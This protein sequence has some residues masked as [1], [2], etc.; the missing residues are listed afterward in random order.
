MNRVHLFSLS[1]LLSCA[2]FPA[3]A[4]P[5]DAPSA[6]PAL[7]ITKPIY[8][9]STESERDKGT[10]DFNHCLVTNMYYNGT[11]LM[12]AENNDGVRRLALH[13]PQST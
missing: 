4:V 7:Q 10:E 12:I 6:E 1:L 8:A 2:A 13:F 5:T 3:L 11:I 9:W